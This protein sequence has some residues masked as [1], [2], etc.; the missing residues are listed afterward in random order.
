VL[1][2]QLL[3]LLTDVKGVFDKPPGD[4][5]AKLLTVYNPRVTFT[6]GDKSVQVG[7][8]ARQGALKVVERPFATPLMC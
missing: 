6:I 4:P 1:V 7:G 3:I 2:C 8:T 5:T